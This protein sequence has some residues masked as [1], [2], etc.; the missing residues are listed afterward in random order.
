MTPLA[1]GGVVI[2]NFGQASSCVRNNGTFCWSWFTSHWSTIFQPALVQH[3]KLTA[4][5]V[6]CGFVLS[7]ALALLAYRWRRLEPPIGIVATMLYTIPSLAAFKILEPF[8]GLG[9]WTAEIP[10]A[11]YTVVLLFGNI[12]TGLREVPPD[13]LEAARGM[14][15]TG[16]QTLLRVQLPLALPSIF[17]GLRIATV[18]T[19]SLATAAAFVIDEGLGSPI[20][21]AI[22]SPF[23]TTFIAASGLA[24]ALAIVADLGLVG[25]QRVLTPWARRR[26]A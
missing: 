3:I 4:I 12:V 16:R 8:T 11:I 10:L 13:V 17:A 5:A 2:P 1:S 20:F 22:G 14:G 19:V 9:L 18:T 23:N 25:L 24:I 15:L 7:F 21:R 26:A 6:G